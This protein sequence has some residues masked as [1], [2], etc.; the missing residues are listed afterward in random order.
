MVAE[1]LEDL[2]APADS[3]A[4]SQSQPV[5]VAHETML[6]PECLCPP[7]SCWN[8][9]PQGGGIRRW[10]PGEVDEVLRVEPSGMGFM[11]S[12]ETPERSLVPSTT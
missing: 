12:Q 5:P 4:W 7:D 2:G 3:S 11:P 10:G 9:I 1:D 8:P 6:W